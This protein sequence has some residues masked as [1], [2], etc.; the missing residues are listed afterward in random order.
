MHGTNPIAK[1]IEN[2]PIWEPKYQIHEIFLTLQGEG[3]R[4]GQ[5]AVFIRLTSCHLRCT[6]CDTHW[7]DANDPVLPLP[8]IVTKVSQL[9]G[10]I[11]DPLVVLTGGEP[12]RQPIDDLAISLI[13]QLNATVQIETAGTFFREC[14]TWHRVETIVSPKTPTVHPRVAERARAYKYVISAEDSFDPVTGVPVTATQAGARHARLAVP[15][16]GFERQSVYLSPCDVED[17][18]KN[19]QN[20]ECAAALAMKHGYVCGV[21]LHKKIGLP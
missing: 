3:P 13:E 10:D 9:W 21:Q 15:P 1:Y 12:T 17:D 5:R 8:E 20:L 4:S 16:L 11:S 18:K 19:Q 6:F 14:M 7:D 2:P